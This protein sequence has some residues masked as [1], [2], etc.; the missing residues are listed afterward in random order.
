MNDPK[1]S[2]PKKERAVAPTPVPRTPAL[3]K[4]GAAAMIAVG[5]AGCGPSQPADAPQQPPQV[6]PPQAPP[7]VP[8]EGMVPP[9]EPPQVSPPPQVPQGPVPQR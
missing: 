8:E 2:L 7:Q 5:L 3:V 1:P 6:E 9:Q 4:R